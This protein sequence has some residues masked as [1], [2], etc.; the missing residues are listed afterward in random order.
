MALGVH[1][2]SK[3]HNLWVE[4]SLETWVSHGLKGPQLLLICSLVWGFLL[5]YIS[6]GALHSAR[7]CADLKFFWKVRIVH[8]KFSQMSALMHTL[9]H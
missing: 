5:L 9:G 3:C 1:G 8:F 7:L 2:C 4:L 6:L